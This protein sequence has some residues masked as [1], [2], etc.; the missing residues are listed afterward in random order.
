MGEQE[1]RMRS[2]AGHTQITL[3]QILTRLLTIRALV[4]KQPANLIALG[5][6]FLMTGFY[7]ALSPFVFICHSCRLGNHVEAH[8]DAVAAA[9]CG[10]IY[11]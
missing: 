2:Q 9:D 10:I 5:M 1:V 8:A 4:H 6:V 7:C 3:G 11:Q